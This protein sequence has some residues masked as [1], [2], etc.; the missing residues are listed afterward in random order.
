MNTVVQ[1]DATQPDAT[2]PDATQP[3]ATQPGAAQPGVAQPG[4]AQTEAQAYSDRLRRAQSDTLSAPRRR[5]G[6]ATRLLIKGMDPVYG[7]SGSFAKYQVLELVARVPY[8]SWERIAY[9]AISRAH[10]DTRLARRIHE[11]IEESRSQQDNEE[12]HLLIMSE[13]AAREGTGQGWLRFRLLPQVVATVYYLLSWL[14]FLTVPAA[15]Y[16]LNADFEDHAEHEYMAFVAAH[17]ELETEP[18]HCPD[19]AGYGSFANIADL[20]RQI[21]CDE[22]HHKDESLAR[23]AEPRLR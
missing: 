2:Q 23:L 19:A 18:W 5:Y 16:R 6:L 1:P 20:V 15:S 22:R 10:R 7:R 13:L 8:Q 11:R 3:D 12:W 21:G 14:L 17:P 9:L 4:V